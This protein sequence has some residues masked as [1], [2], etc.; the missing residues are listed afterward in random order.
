MH[1]AGRLGKPQSGDLKAGADANDHLNE[2]PILNLNLDLDCRPA[3]F[4]SSLLQRN[5]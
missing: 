5:T 4:V 2:P 3:V 1:L